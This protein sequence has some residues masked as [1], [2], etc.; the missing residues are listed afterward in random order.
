MHKPWS[1]AAM[2]FR[3]LASSSLIHFLRCSRALASLAKPSSSVFADEHRI[4]RLCR[5]SGMCSASADGI[6][7][8]VETSAK[9]ETSRGYKLKDQRRTIRSKRR[10]T[11]QLHLSHQ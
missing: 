4:R 9:D 7:E 2:T 1:S 10:M 11:L 3:N 8:A 6:H 5:T